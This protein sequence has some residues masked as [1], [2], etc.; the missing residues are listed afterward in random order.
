[1]LTAAH[2]H[3]PATRRAPAHL[4]IELTARCNSKCRH[5]F[6]RAGP[7]PGAV[8]SWPTAG[9][10]CEEGYGLGYRRLHLTGGEPLLWPQLPALLE[11]VFG[12]G[13][14]S[15]FLN[16][17][18]LLLTAEVAQQLVVFPGLSVS[19]SLQGP[20]ALHDSVRGAGSYRRAARGIAC[21]LAAGLPVTVFSVVGRTLLHQLPSFAAALHEKFCGIERI[22]LIQMIGG[23]T[24]G[25]DLSGELLA[26]EDFPAMVRMVSALNL[27]G[28]AIDVL[29]DPLVNVAADLL[30]VPRVPRSRSLVRPGKLMV[31]ADRTISPAHSIR[32]SY[33]DYTPGRLATVLEDQR[34]REAVA[35]D[36]V[37]CPGCPFRDLCRKHG[38]RHPSVGKALGQPQEP[39]CQSVLNGIAHQARIDFN[40]PAAA[41][42]LHRKPPAGC[43]NGR[44]PVT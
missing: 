13:Y 26:A 40:A 28:I 23:P 10:I 41:T 3:G 9:A 38:M 43:A 5:C 1:M 24:V 37:T 44:E 34:Y 35:A 7:A 20:E 31:R 8:L 19:V 42:M 16:T 27:Y 32:K 36:R 2:D 22:T 6:A 4:S 18:G 15:V 11:R 29:N 25:G 39:Y 33:G 21:A 12:L 14:H 17:N 30:R